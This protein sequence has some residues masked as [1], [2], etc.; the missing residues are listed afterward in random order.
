[1]EN[2]FWA[3]CLPGG[4]RGLQRADAIVGQ[5]VVGVVGCADADA[6]ADIV[7]DGDADEWLW[8]SNPVG[9]VWIEVSPLH[10][11]SLA[12]FFRY[13]NMI[14]EWLTRWNQFVLILNSIVKISLNKK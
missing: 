5:V 2:P 4:Q 12:T 8:W 11:S 6:D 13:P 10:D 7:D 9:D 1:M 3:S 14:M